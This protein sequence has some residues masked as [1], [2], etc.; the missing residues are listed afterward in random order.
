MTTPDST[1]FC[2]QGRQLITGMVCSPISYLQSRFNTLWLPSFWA[3]L[4]DAVWGCRFADDKVKRRERDSKR[5]RERERKCV[6]VR[7]HAHAWGGGRSN[8]SAKS[9]MQPEYSISCKDWKSVLIMETLWKS[10]LNFVKD[11]PI[12]Y[13]NFIVIISN[14]IWENN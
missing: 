13:L 1:L 5:E 9:F 14:S 11:I 7:V 2:V 6:C 12:L 4:K 10:N 8:A 3:P